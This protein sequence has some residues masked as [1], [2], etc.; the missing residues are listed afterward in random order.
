[1]FTEQSTPNPIKANQTHTAPTLLRSIWCQ[2]NFS[3]LPN[4]PAKRDYDPDF[5]QFTRIRMA[6]DKNIY[7]A[8]GIIT[9]VPAL[10]QTH[11]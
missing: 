5:V 6:S 11:T 1:M 7:E 9:K 3:L 8:K 4:Q 2:T 10:I